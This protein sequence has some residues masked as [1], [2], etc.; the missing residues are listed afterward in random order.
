MK[1]LAILLVGTILLVSCRKETKTVEIPTTPLFVKV[2]AVHST[3]EIISTEIV[4]IK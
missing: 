2:D 1:K 4:F 3:G